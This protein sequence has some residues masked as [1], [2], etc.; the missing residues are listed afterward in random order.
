MFDIIRNSKLASADNIELSSLP[1]SCFL[2][3]VIEV[4]SW[5]MPT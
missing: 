1:K 4:W 3:F 5:N 2:Q